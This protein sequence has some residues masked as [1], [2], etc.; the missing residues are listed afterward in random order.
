MSQAKRFARLALLAAGLAG[1]MAQAAAAPAQSP[2]Q[3]LTTAVDQ[4]RDGNS[5]AALKSLE[6]LTK[7]EPNF[8]LAQLLYG[9]LLAAL[10][11][12]RGATLMADSSDPR[13]K[14]LA[15]EAHV[16]LASEKAVPP[17]GA[18]PNSVLKLAPMYKHLIVVDLPRAR[19]YIMENK[20]GELKL[21][22]HH[23]AAMGRNGAGKQTSGDLRTPVGVYHVTGWLKDGELP[24]LYGAGA[25]PV[26]Y[27]NLW[28]QF[29][30]RT[31]RGIWLHG[32]P[33]ETYSRPP[34]SSEGCVTMANDDL[35]SLKP[36]VQFGQTPVVMSDHLEW[37]PKA[38]VAAERAAFLA[39]IED[40]RRKWSARDTAA[41]L[42]YYGADFTTTGMDHAGFVAHKQR[43]NGSKK[44]IEV[45]LSDVNLFR[46]PG[47]E[48]PLV[49]AE[50]TM[51]YRSDNFATVS[52]K[53][54]YWKQAK[55]GEWKI[56]REENR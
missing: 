20:N 35:V 19:L 43:V 52:Q 44:F 48:D 3:Q 51:D 31:G 38:Q 32:V 14:D 10:S 54:Q 49:L 6:A 40:W 42:K 47:T 45:Q 53:Q 46:Y 2:E 25:F 29:K 11:G 4:L 15:E 8:R 23:Y 21:V 41:Y 27:P 56:F 9:E 13:L 17:P 7:R 16:R 5:S 1:G 18:V 24:E 36:Y 30:R 37:L 34:R 22:R 28:D 39:R 55:N 12:A 33:R 26:N 50:F